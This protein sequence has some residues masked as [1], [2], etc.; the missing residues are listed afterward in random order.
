MEWAE[1]LEWEACLASKNWKSRGLLLGIFFVSS[2]FAEERI[3]LVS[4]GVC[5]AESCEQMLRDIKVVECDLTSIQ[6]KR[7]F[8]GKILEKLP[9]R[10]DKDVKKIVF[11]NIPPNAHR[12]FNLHKLPKEKMVLFMWEPPIRMRKM[13]SP[14]VQRCFSKIYTWNDDLVD[15]KNYFKFYYPHKRPMLENLPSFEEKKFCTLIVGATSDKSRHHPNELYSERIK[16]IRFF[17]AI[18]EE[19]FEFY[20]RNWDPSAY[21]SYHGPVEDKLAINKQYKFTICYENCRD[22]PGYVTE[23]IFDCFA[24]GS[25]P[26][27]WGANNVETYIPKDCFIDRRAFS[28]MEELYTFLKSMTAEEYE[29]YLERIC[30]YLDSDQAQVFSPEHYEKIIQ[31][32]IR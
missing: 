17:E 1:C 10:I 26:I 3:E 25:L 21:P 19:G 28:T 9:L 8:W 29:G 31:E 5:S 27:Y 11:M 32:A 14:S 2:L 23:K 13:Y 20:G 18:Q 15:N 30:A 22:L 7:S 24:A 12:N 6:K 4:N 16:A